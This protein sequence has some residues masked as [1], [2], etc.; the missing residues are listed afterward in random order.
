MFLFFSMAGEQLQVVVAKHLQEVFDIQITV[1]QVNWPQFA[2]RH[3]L[4]GRSSS[5]QFLSI[6]LNK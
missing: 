6:D 1:I 5:D 3:L 2:L 4:G